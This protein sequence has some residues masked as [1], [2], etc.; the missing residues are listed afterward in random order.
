VSELEAGEPEE[1]HLALYLLNNPHLYRQLL[2]I[3]SRGAK[4][5]VI[6]IPRGV[7][8]RGKSTLQRRCTRM[9]SQAGL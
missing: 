1:V 2:G 8:T 7:T 5:V 3:A 9:S 4:V 6:T